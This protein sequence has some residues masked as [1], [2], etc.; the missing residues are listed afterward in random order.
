MKRVAGLGLVGVLLGGAMV[1]GADQGDRA[2]LPGAYFSVRFG[3]DKLPSDFRYG[4]RL[5]YDA[6]RY[7]G[8][9]PA[10]LK[11]DFTGEGFNKLM[12]NGL[13]M[14][15]VPYRL[16]QAEA[17]GLLSVQSM[18][19]IGG[20][21]A[22]VAVVA[23]NASDGHSSDHNSGGSSSGGGATSGGGSTNGGTTNGG[24]SVSGGG[25]SV[26]GGGGSVSGGAVLGLALTEIPAG[27]MPSN[28]ERMD[29][30]Y[31]QWLDGGT[32]Q[33]GDLGL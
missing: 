26:S 33:M 30:A 25:G 10:L 28:D 2:T 24:G 8:V 23:T 19:A 21:V 18:V 1:V 4:L 9:L 11:L 15:H 20:S 17:A 29:P 6:N 22:A 13:D 12:I 7:N 16:N 27:A 5:D 31:R 3:G 32:G 14:T